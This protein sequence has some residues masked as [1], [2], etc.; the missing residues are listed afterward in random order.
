MAVQ[1]ILIIDDEI[2]IRKIAQASLKITKGWDVLMAESGSKGVKLAETEQPDAILLDMMM[3]EMDG[4][5]TLK[6]L[7]DN[8]ATAEIP[9]ILLTAK[10]T[11][12]N[13]S[14]AAELGVNSVLIKPF[15]PISLGDLIEAALP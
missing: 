6:C 3:P 9:V 15:D 13:P 10:V 12:A 11:A 4:A 2:D 8:P 5:E 14:I 1:R 7:R